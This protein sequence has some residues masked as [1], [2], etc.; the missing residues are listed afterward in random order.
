MFSSWNETNGK[1]KKFVFSTGRKIKKINNFT[2]FCYRKINKEMK[3]IDRKVILFAFPS[4]QPKIGQKL[5]SKY[6]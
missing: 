3:G 6:M 1:E 2:F 4:N 5:L